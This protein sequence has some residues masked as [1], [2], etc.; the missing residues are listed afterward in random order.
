MYPAALPYLRH[1]ALPTAELYLTA[2]HYAPDGAVLAGWLHPASGAPR[3]PIRAG[4]VDLLGNQ[5]VPITP[6]QLTN[7]LPL[8][9][10]GYERFWRGNAL[11]LLSG[12]AFG[13]QRE[14]P[15]ITYLAQPERGGLYLD[16][17]CS[18]GLYARTLAAHPGGQPRTV[19]GIDHSLPM[20]QQARA[21]ARDARL[22]ITYV[23][24]SAQALPVPDHTAAAVVMGGSLNE[25]GN[26]RTFFSAARRVLQPTGRLVLMY[27]VRATGGGGQMLQQMLGTGG[28]DFPPREQIHRELQQAGFVLQYEQQ[29]GVVVFNSWLPTGAAR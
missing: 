13:Y 27:L 21:Y 26:R 11:T 19:I 23:R 6:A 12:E 20:L 5:R 3:F 7:Y 17:A 18:N 25:I 15:L 10:W 24:A 9:A 1:P 4:I 16:V 22:P 2:E 28:I 8:T 14:L 29:H